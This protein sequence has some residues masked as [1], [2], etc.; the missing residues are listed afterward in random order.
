MHKQWL[1]AVPW[2]SVQTLNQTLCRDKQHAYEVRTA[3]FDKARQLWEKSAPQAMSL[4]EVMMLC[5]RCHDLGPFGF[6][7][8]NTFAAIGK[9]LVED[10]VRTLPP[11]EAQIVRTTVGHYIAGLIG[12]QELVQ[13]LEHFEARW[14][15]A[16]PARPSPEPMPHF[17]PQAQPNA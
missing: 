9:T 7:N 12:K 2:E 11:V 14:T 5:K 16:V 8:G 4:P 13:V 17:Q 6:N 15:A 3:A 10:L 1:N